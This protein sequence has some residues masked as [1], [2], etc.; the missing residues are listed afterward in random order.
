VLATDDLVVS[1]LVNPATYYIIERAG[2]SVE[3]IPHL[4]DQATGRP[5]GQRGIY[6]WWRNTAKPATVNGGRRLAF[7]A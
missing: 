3:T 2:M 6:A 1:A 4:L 5:S 7:K